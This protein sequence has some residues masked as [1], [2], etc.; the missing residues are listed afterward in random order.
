[1]TET[2]NIDEAI[3]KLHKINQDLDLIIKELEKSIS[4]LDELQKR[5]NDIMKGK[6]AKI[7]NR[8]K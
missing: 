6:Y 8:S 5:L 1:M 4:E 7:F 2:Q 3:R